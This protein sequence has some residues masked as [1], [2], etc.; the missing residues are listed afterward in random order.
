MMASEGGF[1]RKGS[2][3]GR[4]TEKA[5]KHSIDDSKHV[6]YVQ[7]MRRALNRKYT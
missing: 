1:S 5:A 7:Y 4:F 2:H 6:S 3:V